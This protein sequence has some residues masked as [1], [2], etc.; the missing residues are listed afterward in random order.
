[1]D[2]KYFKKFWNESTGDELT[3]SW[4]NSTYYFETDENLNVLK[5]IQIFQN[6]NILK[7]DDQN[8]EDQFGFLTDQPLDYND[9]LEN[10]ISEIQ[11]YNIWN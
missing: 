5:Q 3:D 10:E 11:F 4:G 1:M 6:G 2:T 7:Y 9:F 8:L